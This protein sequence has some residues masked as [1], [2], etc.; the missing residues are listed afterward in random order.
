MQIINYVT[1][2]SKLLRSRG[3][4][5]RA[6][7]EHQAAEWDDLAPVRAPNDCEAASTVYTW[8]EWCAAAEQ[9]EA[10][11]MEALE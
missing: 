1:T 7:A 8:A 2:S 10:D 11:P 3:F 5:T 4:A 9:N 6:E